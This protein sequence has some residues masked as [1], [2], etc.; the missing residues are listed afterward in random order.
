[1]LAV[2]MGGA[3]ELSDRARD[4][5]VSAAGRG[6]WVVRDAS[7]GLRALR[8]VAVAPAVAGG[9]GPRR[10]VSVLGNGAMECLGEPLPLTRQ[11][12]RADTP[13]HDPFPPWASAGAYRCT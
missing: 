5:A 2:V 9:S 13:R 3:G 7:G 12:L 6:W 1:M 10:G 4:A 11:P 8:E